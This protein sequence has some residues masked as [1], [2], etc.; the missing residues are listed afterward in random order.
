MADWMKD[1]MKPTWFEKAI[2]G[3]IAV[4]WLLAL[5]LMG[6]IVYVLAHFLGK[7]W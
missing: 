1:A 7:I 2:T 4:I 5:G 6:A 3:F